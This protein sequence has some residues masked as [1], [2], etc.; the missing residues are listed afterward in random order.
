LFVFK[1]VNIL[2]TARWAACGFSDYRLTI[3]LRV[4]QCYCRQTEKSCTVRM[5]DEREHWSVMNVE[6]TGYGLF[7]ITSQHHSG[8]GDWSQTT[9]NFV[10]VGAPADVL[11]ECCRNKKKQHYRLSH[12]CWK[13]IIVV[14]KLHR[15]VTVKSYIYIYMFCFLFLVLFS[16]NTQTL[17]PLISGKNV[18]F[19]VYKLISSDVSNTTK[20]E[21]GTL[22]SKM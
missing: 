14:R 20:L 5:L 22:T 17:L 15:L 9:K 13:T 11:T 1:N 2:N 6:G 3:F 10:I 4:V 7:E 8:G 19:A 18:V 12:L 16:T 21:W